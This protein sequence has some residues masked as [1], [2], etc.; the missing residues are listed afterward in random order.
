M[1]SILFYIA[2]YPGYGGIENVTTLL[3]NY[4]SSEKHYKV[5]ILSCHQQAEEELL[6]KLHTNVNFFKL[7]DPNHTI[8]R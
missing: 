4:L 7:P 8:L 1:K 6:P 2:R 3:A 5:S